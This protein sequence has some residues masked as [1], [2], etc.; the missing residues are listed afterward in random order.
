MCRGEGFYQLKTDKGFLMR[1]TQF[2]LIL[3][4]ERTKIKPSLKEGRKFTDYIGCYQG[5][6]P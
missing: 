5:F 4:D 3:N 2:N 6:F 1:I